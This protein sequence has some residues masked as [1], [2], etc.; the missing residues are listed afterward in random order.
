MKN[1]KQAQS[2]RY[3]WWKSTP[4]SDLVTVLSEKINRMRTPY[5]RVFDSGD[6]GGI[7]D[8]TIWHE[9]VKKC[10]DVKFWFSTKSWIKPEFT[11]QLVSLSKEP[12]VVVRRSA[13]LLDTPATKH[14]I[15]TTAEVHT[16]GEGCPKQTAGSCGA[17]NCRKCWDKKVLTVSY[18]LHGYAVK[19]WNN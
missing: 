18:K 10:P 6:F 12:N 13:L 15:P 16:T 14:L 9:I 1:V 8:V 2:L 19:K 7:R 3:E 17:A 5:I 11:S 4:S